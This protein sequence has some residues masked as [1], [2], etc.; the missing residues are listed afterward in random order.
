MQ[1][2]HIS[3]MNISGNIEWWERWAWNDK[4][5]CSEIEQLI[6]KDN[7]NPWIK[8]EKRRW[9]KKFTVHDNVLIPVPSQVLNSDLAME[10]T[11]LR[12]NRKSW[13]TI[14]FDLFTG[15]DRSS[16]DLVIERYPVKNLGVELNEEWSFGYPCWLSHVVT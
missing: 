16:L 7:K 8:I 9:Q 6:Y 10:I 3:K 13:W 1:P 11:E 14:G 4:T 12:L 2:Y 15:A 5:T